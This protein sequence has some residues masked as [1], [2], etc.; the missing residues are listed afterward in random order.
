MAFRHHCART[1]KLQAQ[2]GFDEPG[3]IFYWRGFFEAKVRKVNAVPRRH[4]PATTLFLRQPTALC[5]PSAHGETRGTR[6]G[7]GT[8]RTAGH[9]AARGM[10]M[11]VVL[12]LPWALNQQLLQAANKFLIY[13]A[14]NYIRLPVVTVCMKRCFVC[15][16]R[17]AH[18]KSHT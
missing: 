7:R 5:F 16:T 15:E 9:A 18:V 11:V 12:K 2:S 6:W 17:H 14:Y 13:P 4:F 10:S 3:K 8:A 1:S